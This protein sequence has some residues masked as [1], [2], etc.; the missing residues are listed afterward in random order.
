MSN[1]TA[2]KVIVNPVT[3]EEMIALLKTGVKGWNEFVLRAYLRSANLSGADLRSANLSGANLSGADLSGANLSG[4]DL[5]GADLRSAYLSGANLS[6]AYLRS[7]NLSGA[8]LSGADLSGAYLQ[9]AGGNLREI[10]SIHC[11][12]R[13]ITYSADRMWIGCQNYTLE[14][15][16]SFTDA[17]ISKM[18]SEALERWTKWKPLLRQIIAAYPATPII[19]TEKTAQL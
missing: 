5:S 14:E 6:G 18:S 3:K 4:A 1:E 10:R 15:W 13:V 9:H 7:A 8:D 17:E 19:V 11:F 2:E 12:E 16:W